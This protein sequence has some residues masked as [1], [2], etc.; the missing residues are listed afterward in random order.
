LLT[1]ADELAL[2]RARHW[3]QNAIERRERFTP[4]VAMPVGRMRLMEQKFDA[5]IKSAQ[6][7]IEALEAQ[8]WRHEANFGGL[9]VA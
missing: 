1:E 8:A 6:A 9:D 5:N 4:P 2:R 3:L 7:L